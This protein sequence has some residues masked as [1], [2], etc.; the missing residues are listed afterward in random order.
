MYDELVMN[1]QMTLNRRKICVKETNHYLFKPPIL[2][3]LSLAHPK[4]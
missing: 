2:K 4:P 3:V 1:L